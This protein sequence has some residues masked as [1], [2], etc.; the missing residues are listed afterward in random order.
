MKSFYISIVILALII[1]IISLNFMYINNVSKN[2]T[3]SV[4]HIQSLPFEEREAEV[5]RLEQYWEQERKIVSLSVRYTEIDRVDDYVISVSASYRDGNVH[6]CNQALAL[7]LDAAKELARL[8]KFD[9]S[10]I[11]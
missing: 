3:E 6:D 1:L 11:M 4:S 5:R 7:M 10:N 2:L 9:F 8:E